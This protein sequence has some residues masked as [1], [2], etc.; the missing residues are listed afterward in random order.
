MP[1]QAGACFYHHKL[2]NTAGRKIVKE[3]TVFCFG[4]TIFI[5]RQHLY[6]FVTGYC[7]TS[8]GIVFVF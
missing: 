8:Q 2:Q 6:P 1:Q 3:G 4:K 5:I 7:I